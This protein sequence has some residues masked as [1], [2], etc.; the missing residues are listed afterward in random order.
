MEAIKKMTSISE[1]EPRKALLRKIR[2]PIFVSH[3]QVRTHSLART[4]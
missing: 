3:H 2:D 4:P 1:L